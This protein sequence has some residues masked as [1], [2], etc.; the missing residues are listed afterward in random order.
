MK[1]I[2]KRF[3]KISDEVSNVSKSETD[4]SLDKLEDYTQ[5]WR[6]EPD[7]IKRGLH[8][9]LITHL[10]AIENYSCFV[11]YKSFISTDTKVDIDYIKTYIDELLDTNCTIYDAECHWIYS[12]TV[13]INIK[14]A[15]ESID[16][17]LWYN[18]FRYSR[19]ISDTEKVKLSILYNK[20]IRN[21]LDSI[22]YEDFIKHNESN[23]SILT[24]MIIDI[25]ADNRSDKSL[26][27]LSYGTRESYDILPIKNMIFSNLDQVNKY[28]ELYDIQLSIVFKGICIQVMENVNE[29]R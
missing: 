13:I 4:I 3:N 24:S 14:I 17:D 23:L 18:Y 19:I 15:F 10:T 5:L 22:I 7:E 6:M 12:P 25:I 8:D 27:E 21:N 1:N 28:Y 2:F 16:V 20:Y 9:I 26:I 11:L 29:Y